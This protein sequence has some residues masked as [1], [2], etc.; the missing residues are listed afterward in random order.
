MEFQT[1][2][3]YF[4]ALKTNPELQSKF[5]EWFDRCKKLKIA[6]LKLPP[7]LSTF[8]NVATR[9][10]ASAPFRSWFVWARHFSGEQ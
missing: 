8:A 9:P 4:T 2:L 3:K 10:L 7:Q 1:L 5:C 6:E